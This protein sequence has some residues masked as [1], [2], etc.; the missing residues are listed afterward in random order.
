MSSDDLVKQFD[1]FLTEAHRLKASYAPRIALLVGLETEYIT[2]I[3]MDHLEDFLEHRP[4][5]IEYIVG[6]V[7]HVNR[8]PIDFDLPTF[9]KALASFDG[10]PPPNS[11]F[12]QM[13]CFLSSY[14]DAQYEILHRLHP[15]VIGHIDLCRLYNPDLQ[16]QEYP[17]AWKKLERNVDYA[18][19][20]GALFEV[21][22]A[23][24]RKGWSTAYPGAD[25]M[26][27]S[28]ALAF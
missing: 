6:S 25:V 14:F 24:F 11:A 4:G 17:K 15:E 1:S 16:L 21:N 13:E 2:S 20:Y 18:I 10:G 27:A 26:Q 12:Q 3:D 19:S 7:H 8:I 22:A 28:G 23:A 5:Q 9:H